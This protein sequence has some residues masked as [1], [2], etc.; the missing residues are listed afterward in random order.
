M[1]KTD[2]A[3]IKLKIWLLCEKGRKKIKTREELETYNIGTAISYVSISGIY[4]EGGFITKFEKDNFMYIDND[5][6][7]QQ[8][9][10]DSRRLCFDSR[11]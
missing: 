11:I 10:R 6:K 3:E 5:F 1:V 9:F 8:C 7:K 4:Y 2:R